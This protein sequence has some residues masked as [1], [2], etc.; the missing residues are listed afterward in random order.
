MTY[1]EQTGNK[2]RIAKNTFVL[3]ARSI[4][5]MRLFRDFKDIKVIGIDSLTAFH[6]LTVNYT[7]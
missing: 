2:K 3:Y 7:H 1:D 4:L 6:G 5:V